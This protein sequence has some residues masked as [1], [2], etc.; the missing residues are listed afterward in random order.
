MLGPTGRGGATNMTIN[1]D[2]STSSS[3]QASLIG[4]ST[5]HRQRR[6]PSP[7]ACSSLILQPHLSLCSGPSRWAEF[8]LL[9]TS[10]ASVNTGCPSPRHCRLEVTKTLPQF[11]AEATTTTVVVA[12]IK[13]YPN[14]PSELNVVYQPTSGFHTQQSLQQQAQ[15]RQ[16]SHFRTSV[17]GSY[18]RELRA[19][20]S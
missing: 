8:F 4:S 1:I 10:S 9:M 19:A 16:T 14:Q 17:G 15:C 7:I 13:S 2:T 12:L 20:A 11:V 6:P 18:D 5:D 3:T